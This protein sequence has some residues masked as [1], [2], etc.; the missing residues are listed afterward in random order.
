MTLLPVHPTRNE[1]ALDLTEV[2][3]DEALDEAEV[4]LAGPE[5]VVT[6][7]VLATLEELA[8]A[9]LAAAALALA[10]AISAGEAWVALDPLTS[11]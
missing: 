5:T 7:A 1:L 2:V 8:A 10:A 9:A 11:R 3:A 6:F 4:V